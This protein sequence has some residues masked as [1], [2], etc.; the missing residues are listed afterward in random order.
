MRGIEVPLFSH[1]NG[2]MSGL[3][4]KEDRL[5]DGK[6]VCPVFWVP[7][8]G[9][10]THANSLLCLPFA[11]VHIG[12]SDSSFHMSFTLPER[13]CY[14]SLHSSLVPVVAYMTI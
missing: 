10:S 6:D 4:G 12:G 11:Y 3:P 13:T 5:R 1:G 14:T 7:K 2:R 9:N 8:K